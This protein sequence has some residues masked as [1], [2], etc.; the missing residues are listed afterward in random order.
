VLAYLKALVLDSAM[1]P[2]LRLECHG[3]LVAMQA[4]F[5]QF[6]YLELDDDYMASTWRKSM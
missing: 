4:I 1:S 5:H 2:C 6:V 3:T